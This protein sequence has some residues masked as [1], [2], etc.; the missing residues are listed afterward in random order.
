MQCS[1]SLVMAVVIA[2]H[3]E[4]MAA[5]ILSPSNCEIRSVNSFCTFRTN[6]Q[7]RSTANCATSMDPT[8]MADDGVDNSL[9]AE[10]MCTMKTIVTDARTDGKCVA[11]SFAELALH[12]FRTLWSIPP[13]A[14]GRRLSV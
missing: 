9:K 2:L 6:L 14:V 3:K 4:K 12:N 11:S 5:L 13:D 1:F 8:V 10:P 7:Q